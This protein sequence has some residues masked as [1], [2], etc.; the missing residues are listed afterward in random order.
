MDKFTKHGEH[1][2]NQRDRK[3]YLRLNSNEPIREPCYQ[4]PEFRG[5][6]IEG[7]LDFGYL[8]VI[9]V[10]LW[11][12]GRID[13]Y[14]V[15]NEPIENIGKKLKLNG[16]HNGWWLDDYGNKKKYGMVNLDKKLRQMMPG[17]RRFS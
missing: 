4:P 6:K 7:N 5:F 12:S 3:Q 9:F 2:Q 11:D 1:R 15:R 14:Y 13:S 17:I 8:K 10:S 16:D